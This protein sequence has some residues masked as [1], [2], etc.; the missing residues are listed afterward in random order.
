MLDRVKEIRSR[1]AAATTRQG[2]GAFMANAWEDMG[3]LLAEVD[4]AESFLADV[5]NLSAEIDA[6]T[7]EVETLRD[8]NSEY[9]TA[10]DLLEQELEELRLERKDAGS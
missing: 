4:R 2:K 5:D 10:I 1:H 6:L 7:E 9:E 3:F 8:A